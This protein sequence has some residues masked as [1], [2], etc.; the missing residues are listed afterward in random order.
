[1][2]KYSS[3]SYEFFTAVKSGCGDQKHLSIIVKSGKNGN[4]S[5]RLLDGFGGCNGAVKKNLEGSA[6]LLWS[7][8]VGPTAAYAVRSASQPASLAAIYIVISTSTP[9][10]FLLTTPFRCSMLT[11]KSTSILAKRSRKGIRGVKYIF[12]RIPSVVIAIQT[13]RGPI[14]LSNCAFRPKVTHFNSRSTI[15]RNEEMGSP[16]HEFCTFVSMKVFLILLAKD[17]CRKEILCHLSDYGNA[18]TLSHLKGE[19][20]RKPHLDSS[21][22]SSSHT[23][24]DQYKQRRIHSDMKTTTSTTNVKRKLTL[25]IHSGHCRSL[26]YKYY[27]VL[28]Y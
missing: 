17:L 24:E 5:W 13:Q 3:K 20:P 6:A 27:Y 2:P 21:I 26:K 16:N 22:S 15:L 7:S 19:E 8:M 12:C 9:T 25:M 14:L 1:M 4:W 28:Q 10:L 11:L 18:T 23:G